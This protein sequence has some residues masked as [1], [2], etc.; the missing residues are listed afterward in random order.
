MNKK[1]KTLVLSLCLSTLLLAACSNGSNTEKDTT[2]DPDSNEAGTTTIH[3]VTSE[4][5]SA[6]YP[7]GDDITNNVWIKRYN[8]KFNIDVKTDWV[9][10]EYDTKLNL[11]IASNDLPDV[12]RVNPSQL[13]QLVEADMVMDLSEVF[14]QH[15]SDRLKGYM[16][17]DADSYESGKRMVSYT[18]Y[19]RCTGD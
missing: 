10:D 19:R 5:T 15:A 18:A 8:E 13:R 14:D 12:F 2:T 1:T 9:S 4:Y 16:E 17:A 6:K 11:A 3:T 7:K